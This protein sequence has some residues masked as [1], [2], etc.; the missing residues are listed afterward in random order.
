MDVR[1]KHGEQQG[2]YSPRTAAARSPKQQANA[3]TDLRDS[4]EVDEYGWTGQSRRD[5]SS[6][7][8]RS[9]EMHHA[10]SGVEET[11]HVEKRPFESNGNAIGI[12]THPVL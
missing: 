4:G 3:E 11:H 5:D 8:S 2:Y 1:W 7:G 12:G 6:E 10:C 9:D